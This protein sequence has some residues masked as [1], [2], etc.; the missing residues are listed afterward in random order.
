LKRLRDDDMSRMDLIWTY[1]YWITFVR[2]NRY[3][4]YQCKNR[5][6]RRAFL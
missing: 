2:S 5:I 4:S 1:N 6:S 3:W